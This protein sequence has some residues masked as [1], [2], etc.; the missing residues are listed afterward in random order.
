MKSN[1]KVEQ[2]EQIFVCS[3]RNRSEACRI[4]GPSKLF[5]NHEDWGLFHGDITFRKI[6]LNRFPQFLG[7]IFCFTPTRTTGNLTDVKVYFGADFR[8]TRRPMK[9]RNN[10]PQM[11]GADPGFWSGGPS[12]VWGA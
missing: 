3:V 5:R 7:Q 9:E 11:P 6:F 4:L 2:W 8:I 12:G 10:A 1:H